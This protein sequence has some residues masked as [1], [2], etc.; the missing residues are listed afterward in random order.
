MRAIIYKLFFL[1]GLAASFF[2]FS[3]QAHAMITTEVAQQPKIK[4]FDDG[5]KL[6]FSDVISQGQE[7]DLI[8]A[9]YSHSSHRS[10][11]SHYS[12]RS[13]RY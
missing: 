7:G 8:A 5:G 12:H 6:Y 2:G 3:D 11:S 9:H 10:H 4:A 13:S 1:T